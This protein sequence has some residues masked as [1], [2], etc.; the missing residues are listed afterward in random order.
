VRRLLPA[1]A[2]AL[3][4]LTAC[5]STSSGGSSA[6]PVPTGNL[7][8]VS[9]SYGDK[10]TL[11][12]PNSA[13]SK[14]L[15]KQVLSEGKGAPVAK[16]D[17]LVADYLGQIWK[18][19]VFDNS[20]D[21]KLPAAFP[22]GVGQVIT[23]WDE[24]LV[25]VKAGSRVLLS[26]PPDKGYGTSGNSQ[27]GISGTDT[28]VFVVD[29][30]KSYPGTAAGDPKATPQPAPTTGPQVTGELGKQPTVTVPKGTPE[31]KAVTVTVLAKGSGAPVKAG[32]VVMQYEVV[33]WTGKSVGST[34]KAGSP[35]GEPSGD[36]AN[37]TVFDKLAGVPI[38]S[39]VL[40]TI[41]AS[42]SQPAVAVA[43]DII[44]Q[45]GTAKEAAAAGQ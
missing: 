42:S 33:D 15:E 25:G 44:D 30:V 2:A 23:G 17:L 18:G 36:A 39:R 31:P 6:S 37:P 26:I 14:T 5:G 21:R 40:M 41:P 24:G 28:L 35:V 9:G 43:I 3:V 22:I 8:A 29:I 1:V 10:P 11:T 13:P 34:W 38:G 19:K 32:L 45:P 12:F 20:Y 7:P 27:A 16:G 4:L